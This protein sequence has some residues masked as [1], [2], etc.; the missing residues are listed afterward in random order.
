VRR[1]WTPDKDAILRRLYPNALAKDLAAQLGRGLAAIY[2]RAAS[3]G[4]KKS[5]E[6]MASPLASRLR[7]G[8][9]VGKAT[10]FK[11]GQVP[12]NKGL[13]RPGWAPGRMRETQFKPGV[14]QGIAAKNWRPIGT[15]LPDADGYLRIKIREATPGEAY[16]F[17]NVRVWPLLQRHVWQQAHGPI[18]HGHNIV[19]K[20]GNRAN[21]AL[22]NLECIPRA[23]MMKRNSVHNLPAPLPQTIQLLGA[24]KRQIRRKSRGE[25]QDSGPA[26]PPVRDA[27]SAE[28]QREADGHRAREGHR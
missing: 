1:F 5:P 14:R 16:G 10:Q 18:P 26:R 6:F 23:E 12:A 3:L 9:H 8:D 17:G 22:E 21:C 13:R 24:L 15:I 11:K 27:R 2:Q 7:R 28:G 4:L 19:F 25:E 20:D